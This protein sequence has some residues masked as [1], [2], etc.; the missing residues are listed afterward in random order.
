M[1]SSGQLGGLQEDNRVAEGIVDRH[2]DGRKIKWTVLWEAW[3]V[4]GTPALRGRW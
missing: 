4:D 3:S 1:P 2:S